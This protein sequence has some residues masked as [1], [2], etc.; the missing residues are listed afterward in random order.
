MR[1]LIVVFS[2]AIILFLSV[3]SCTPTSQS[4]A[5][6]PPPAPSAPAPAP[7]PMP[8]PAQEPET[9]PEAP[10]IELKVHFINLSAPFYDA[11]LLDLGETEILIDG[12]YPESGLVPYIKDHIDGSLEVMVVTHPHMDHMWVL[13]EVL[14]AFDVDEVWLNGDSSGVN[15]PPSSQPAFDLFQQ[16]MELVN[17]EGASIREVRRGQSIDVDVLTFH[18]LH[19]VLPL[20]EVDSDDSAEGVF[21]RSANNNSIV[22]R[23]SYGNIAFLFTGEVA[24]E[25]EASILEA[26]LEVQA[27]ILKVGHHGSP[28]SSSTQ[29]LESVMPRIAIYMTGDPEVRKLSSDWNF[30][31]KPHPDTIAALNKVGAEVYGTDINGTIVITTDGETYTVDTEK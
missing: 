7:A 14:D 26:G 21:L 2:I 22:L 4:P 5:Y 3:L 9:T 11:I 25:A 24:T 20:F 27:D 29:F 1:R 19:P 8:A 10:K 30:I 6:T 18:V 12:G 28:W 16:F 31:N 23:L 15:I 17:T 13:F